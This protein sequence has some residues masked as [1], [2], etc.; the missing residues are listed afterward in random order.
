MRAARAQSAPLGIARRLPALGSPAKASL[1]PDSGSDPRDSQPARP[2]LRH[3]SPEPF[4]IQPAAS[5]R[6][7]G[8]LNQGF[9]LGSAR[10]N[11]H[12][13]FFSLLTNVF[14]MLGSQRPRR[15][16]MKQVIN[17]YLINT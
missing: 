16:L 3:P 10:S 12:S 17:I 7:T 15:L 13:V 4:P 11:P 14:R 8:F 2:P 9:D 5:A 6:S 1:I